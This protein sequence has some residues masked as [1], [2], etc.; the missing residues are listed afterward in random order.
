MTKL[1]FNKSPCANGNIFKEPVQYDALQRDYT[2][3]GESNYKYCSDDIKLLFAD[4]KPCTT[5]TDAC[6]F[7]DQFIGNVKNSK[8]LAF[9]SF[10]YAMNET[11]RLFKKDLNDDLKGFTQVTEKL[12]SMNMSSINALN[13]L[14]KAGLEKSRLVQMCFQN[15]YVIELLNQYG[16]NS[17]N[18]IKIV[19]NV[20]FIYVLF[21]KV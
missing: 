11:N 5:G 10:W 14:N 15:A 13:Q 16:F 8:F 1:L 20:I 21:I 3:Y 2:F 17:M 18:G 7:K 19:D 6:S 12:C 9:S 4:R